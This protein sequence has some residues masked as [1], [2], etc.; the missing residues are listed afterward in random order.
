MEVKL[1]GEEESMK[2]LE[3]CS[4]S[5]KVLKSH[6]YCLFLHLPP[7]NLATTLTS[8]G[9]LLSP[10]I[11]YQIWPEVW[12]LAAMQAPPP[13]S[14]VKENPQDRPNGVFISSIA[15]LP[16]SSHLSHRR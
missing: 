3:P 6:K 10:I 11:H 12:M 16:L 5:R 1:Q 4:S 2:T 15:T 14:V 8:L 7:T 13:I 9:N